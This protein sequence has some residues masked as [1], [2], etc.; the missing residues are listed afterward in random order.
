MAGAAK[1]CAAVSR[2]ELEHPLVDIPNQDLFDIPRVGEVDGIIQTADGMYQEYRLANFNINQS[3][4]S[5]GRQ[6]DNIRFRCTLTLNEAPR[7]L[8]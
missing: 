2:L 1:R 5:G 4:F 6:Q 3:A 8:L 7:R